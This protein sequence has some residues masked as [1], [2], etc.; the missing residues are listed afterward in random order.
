MKQLYNRFKIQRKAVIVGILLVLSVAK[1]Y[2]QTTLM[3]ETFEGGTHQLLTTSAGYNG[4][5]V[6]L[7]VDGQSYWYITS[8]FYSYCIITGSNSLSV[9]SDDYYCT[10]GNSGGVAYSSNK[11]AY[12][13]FSATGY[14]SL[15]VSFNYKAGGETSYDYGKVCY[16]TNGTTWTDLAG[17]YN[18]KASTTAV[19]N[20]ALPSSLDGLST[21]YIGFRW[22]NNGN[23]VDPTVLGFVVDD[24]VVKGSTACSGTPSAPVAGAAT[25]V[26]VSTFTANWTASANANAYLLDVSTVNTFASFVTGYNA[27]A[28]G[29]VTT[30]NVTGLSANTTYYYRVRAKCTGTSTSSST[31]SL[32]TTLSYCSTT[33]VTA[34]G[35]GITNVTFNTINNTTGV[36]GGYVDYTSLSTTVNPSTAYN[37]TVKVNTNGAWTFY[38]KAWIDWN[39]DGTFSTTTE[40]YAMGTVYNLANGTSS[41]CPLSITVPAGATLGTTRMRVISR[42]NSYAGPCQA[43]TYSGEVEDYTI[44][45][46]NPPGTAYGIYAPGAVSGISDCEIYAEGGSGTSGCLVCSPT[47]TSYTNVPISD[48]PVITAT[49]ISCTS[50]NITIATSA[51]SPDWTGSTTPLTSTGASKTITYST[52]GRKNISLASSAACPGASTTTVSPNTAITDDGCSSATGV[53]STIAVSGYGTCKINTANMSVKINITHGDIGD[54]WIYLKAPNNK[55]ICVSTGNGGTAN[56]YTNVTFSDA[57]ATNIASASTPYSGTYKPEGSTG[58]SSCGAP[59][60]GVTTFLALGGS[61]YNPTGNWTLTVFDDNAT[62][63]GTFVDWTLTLPAATGGGTVNST[64]TGFANMM[65]APPSVGSVQGTANGCPGGTYSYSSTAAGTPGFTYLW[66]VS[67]SA[68]TTIYSPTSSSTNIKF[69]TTVTTYTIS[70]TQSTECCGPLTAIT[71][72]TAI[73]ASPASPTVTVGNSTPCVGGSTTL[74]PTAPANCTFAFYDALTGGTLLSSTVPYITPTMTVKDTIFVEAISTNGCPSTPRASIIITPAT[75]A[76]PTISGVTRCGTG[77]VTLEVTSPGSG[78]IYEWHSGSCAG[79]LLQSNTGISYTATG[80]SATTTFYVSATPR[81]CNASLCTAVV[82]TVNAQGSSYTWAGTASGANNWFTASNWGGSG[83]IP[84]CASDVTIPASSGYT[85]PPDIGYNTTGRAAVK[86]ITLTSTCTLSFSDAKAELSICGNFTHNGTLTT[87]GKGSIIFSGTAAQTYAKSTGTGDFNDVVINNTAGT[88]TLT[89]SNDLTLGTGG[90]LIF[91]SGKVITGANN[92]IIK[93]TQSGAISGHSVSNYVEGNLRRYINTG[94]PTS[95]DFPVGNA[96]KG[97]ELAN[98]NFTTAPSTIT[99]LTANFNTYGSVPSS[100]GTTECFA[101]YNQSA[102]NHGYWTISANNSQ[103]NV[104]TYNMTLYNRGY[105]NAQNGGSIMSRHNGSSTWGLLNGDGTASTC[106]NSPITAIERRNMKGFSDFGVAQSTSVLPIELLSFDAI[107]NGSTTDVNWETASE[108]NNNYFT[109]ERSTDASEFKAIAKVPSKA[110]GGN[111]TSN[112]TYTL[113]D[114]DVKKGVYYYRLKQTD[115]DG[116]TTVSSVATVSIDDHQPLV[117]TPNPTDNNAEISF[118]SYSNAVAMLKVYDTRGRL[119]LAKELICNKGHNTHT[120]D[121][122]NEISGVFYIVLSVGDKIYNTK[123]LKQ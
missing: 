95:Y 26:G 109:I 4:W 1:G 55:V 71:Y 18:N 91:Q 23:Y 7:A 57:G 119:V 64:Y 19:T 118:E 43:A 74:T 34:Q 97:Y 9:T 84:T 107:Y 104:G 29:N 113:N 35:Y 77:D 14:A 32:T 41:S 117:V 48:Y 73:A 61:A 39:Q 38:Q 16:S 51:T 33:A 36:S 122:H 56:N 99:Y 103:N 98:V 25:N 106:I 30:Y 114:P 2:S 21:V 54:L 88:P 92:V 10:Y 66:S 49:N 60:S 76:P 58:S 17:T 40:E 105:T 90:N 65:M 89:L 3:S 85:Y 94:T 102:L 110:K 87:N 69:P 123:L 28:V 63:S 121:L 101:T 108:T 47:S 50:T 120:I 93:N 46:A 100:L 42:Y 81:G 96:A 80:L 112:L 79:T 53:T 111:S 15:T 52:T 6:Y 75:T 24:I 116:K 115:Y 27:K 67:P 70:C 59:T 37:L 82:A 5:R 13:S 83:C 11:V 12:K 44:E 45:V 22:V 72:T 8:S 62:S 20:L 78:Y 86:S 68:G 31:I